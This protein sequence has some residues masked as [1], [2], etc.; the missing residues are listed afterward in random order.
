MNERELIGEYLNIKICKDLVQCILQ[1]LYCA[2]LCKCLLQIGKQIDILDTVQKWYAGT[3]L[4][5]KNNQV[6]VQYNEWAAKWCEWL[7]I[8]SNGYC[9][10][11]APYKT[12][13][14]N[15]KRCPVQGFLLKVDEPNPTASA[16]YI[17]NKSEQL[18]LDR[19]CS[20]IYPLHQFN[21]GLIFDK[22][23]IIQYIL[24]KQCYCLPANVQMMKKYVRKCQRSWENPQSNLKTHFSTQSSVKLKLRLLHIQ[25]R[26]GWSEKRIKKTQARLNRHY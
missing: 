15:I 23:G 22:I 21:C 13:S 8:D 11:I 4:D 24:S 19:Y 7:T 14:I 2:S 10:R 5:V 16:S 9:S 20:R 26:K 12:F 25:P 18:Y 6:Y 17:Y 1:Y 3:I